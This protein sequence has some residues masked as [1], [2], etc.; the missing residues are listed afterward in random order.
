MGEHGVNVTL[1]SVGADMPYFIGYEAMPTERLTVL[2]VRRDETPVLLIPRLEV[3][4]VAAGEFEIL[5]W[6]EIDDPIDLA[7]GVAGKPESVAVG[8]HMWSSFLIGFRKRWPNAS[9]LAA[10]QLTSDLRLRKE[11]GEVEALR[12]AAQGVDRAMARIPSEVV[13]AGRSERQIAGQLQEMTVEEGHDR[14]EFAIVGSGPNSAS[15]HHEPGARIVTEGDM[16][17]CDFG[18]RWG[19]YYSDSTRTFVVGEPTAEQTEVHSVVLA[20]NEAGRQ[21]IRPGVL[22]E[23]IDSAARTV[24]ADAGYADYFIHRTGHGI[25][26]EIHEHPYMVLGNDQALEPGMAFSIEPGVYLPNYFGVRIEDIV[27]CEEDGV[28][29]LNESSRTLNTVA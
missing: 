15:P 22:C 9:W 23:E 4:R 12:Q 25:G 18:G 11:P 3:P 24:I 7:A 28:N 1:L 20:A 8:D 10:S 17:V 21:A 13:F 26:L 6:D 2:V 27:V 19:G 14:A 5:T 16:V 29:S